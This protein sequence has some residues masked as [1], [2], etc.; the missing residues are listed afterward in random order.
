MNVVSP[1]LRVPVVVTPDRI[2]STYKFFHLFDDV[3]RSYVLS[4]YGTT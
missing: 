3:P 4:T 2:L 1:V